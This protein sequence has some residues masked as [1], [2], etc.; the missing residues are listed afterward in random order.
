MWARDILPDLLDRAAYS[1]RYMT[2]GYP[3]R[4]IDW[5]TIPHNLKQTALGLLDQILQDRP[6]VCDLEGAVIT[7]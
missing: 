6:H 1:G 4:L 3:A 7:V 2:Y 5:D